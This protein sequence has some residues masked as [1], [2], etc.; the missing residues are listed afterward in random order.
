M[1]V[2]LQL[3]GIN[4]VIIGALMLVVGLLSTL[5]GYGDMTATGYWLLVAGMGEATALGL[6]MYSSAKVPQV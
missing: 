3:L 2:F 6:A 5:D 4:S 1:N